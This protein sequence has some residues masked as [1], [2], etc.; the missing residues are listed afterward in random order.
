MA[1]QLMA[2]KPLRAPAAVVVNRLGGELLAGAGLARDEHRARRAGDDLEQLKQVAHD[3]A[4]ADEPVDAIALL[5]LRA[6]IGVLGLQP[7]LL[8]GRAEHVQQRVE[9]KR[10]GDEVRG[11]LLDR[12]DR[13]LHGAVAGDHDGDDVGV[14]LEGGVE[15]LPAVD[16]GQSEVGDEDVEGEVR[17]AGAR[18]SSPLSACSTA[19]P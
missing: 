2:T 10:L 19:N 5:Q 15:H 16:A 18:A 13:V 17:Q 3:P 7:P 6:Q 11:A 9:L 4:S 12:V 8:H 14:A 1:L